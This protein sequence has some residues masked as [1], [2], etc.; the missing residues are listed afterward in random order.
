MAGKSDAGT[1]TRSFVLTTSAFATDVPAPT[2]PTAVSGGQKA[3]KTGVA[4]TAGVS[5]L[6]R[7]VQVATSWRPGGHVQATV[8]GA[9]GEYG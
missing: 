7:R 9:G 3:P 1:L 6:Q 5:K 2:T 8:Y 4:V